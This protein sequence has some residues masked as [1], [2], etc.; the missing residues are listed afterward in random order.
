[1]RKL[2]RLCG[3]KSFVLVWAL[4]VYTKAS[5]SE[6][7]SVKPDQYFW[8]GYE[9]Y[10]ARSG[11]LRAR[12]DIWTKPKAGSPIDIAREYIRSAAQELGIPRDLNGFRVEERTV[13]P[14]KQITFI[15]EVRNVPVYCAEIR[16]NMS[17]DNSIINIVSS[18]EPGARVA[19]TNPKISGP[20]AEAFV[21]QLT[22]AITFT[23]PTKLF[24][25]AETE[26]EG[27]HLV[28]LVRTSGRPGL[29]PERIFIDANSEKVWRREPDVLRFVDGTGTVFHP[30]PRTTLSNN[31]LT[32]QNNSNYIDIQPAYKTGVALR[33]LNDPVNNVYRVQGK[34][35]TSVD[36]QSLGT[37]PNITPVT[38]ATPDFSFNRS[39]PGFEEVMAYY[40]IDTFARY[41]ASLPF[42]NYLINAPVEF[43]AHNAKEY[44]LTEY[45]VGSQ[46]I[47]LTEND[48]YFGVSNPNVDAGEDP[49]AI[50]HEL[51]HHF[52]LKTNQPFALDTSPEAIRIL[53]G[54][55]DYFG[56]SY[57]RTTPE[58]SSFNQELA[59]AWYL[60]TH[61]T[62]RVLSDLYHYPQQ[63]SGTYVPGGELW[64]ST[65]MD[66]EE[67]LGRDITT[68]LIFKALTFFGIGETMGQAALA[69]VDADKSLFAGQHV[70]ALVGVFARRGMME[71]MAGPVAGDQTWAGCCLVAGDVSFTS[72]SNLF[73]LPGATVV[74]ACSPIGSNLGE[75]PAGTEIIVQGRLQANG[76]AESPI[77][78]LS[79]SP[80]PASGDC[81]GFI[82]NKTGTAAASNVSYVTVKD[83]DWGICAKGPSSL[84]ASNVTVRDCTWGIIGRGTSSTTITGLVTQN[85]ATGVRAYETGTV[86]LSGST[87]SAGI[88][89]VKVEDSGFVSSSG[90][91]IY[92]SGTGFNVTG[93]H[94]TISG[95]KIASSSTGTGVRL[96]GSGTSVVLDNNYVVAPAATGIWGSIGTLDVRKGSVKNCDWGIWVDGSGSLNVGGTSVGYPDVTVSSCSI[97]GIGIDSPASCVLEDTKV[98]GTSTANWVGIHFL[99]GSNASLGFCEV[100]NATGSGS[101]GIFVESDASLTAPK[102]SQIAKTNLGAG[103]MFDADSLDTI[104]L[105]DGNG[106]TWDHPE[107]KDCY[108]GLSIM[109]FSRPV[110]KNSL[111]K[112]NQMYGVQIGPAAVPD[113]GRSNG[114]P[115]W[116]RNSIHG[117]GSSQGALLAGGPIRLGEFGTVK[118]EKN[119]WGSPIKPA[120]FSSWVDYD[121]TLT[122]D[123]IPVAGVSIEI[124]A[125][126]DL[127]PT[128]PPP[129]PM[130]FVDHVTIP[131]RV[132]KAGESVNIAIYDVAGRLVRQLVDGTFAFG[133]HITVWDGRGWEG[134]QFVPP[135]VYFAKTKIGT[136]I[137]TSK[138]V[139][140]R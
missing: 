21:Q 24:V 84:T 88:N 43:D 108:A 1:M 31:T 60:T 90:D 123:P 4:I 36:V 115:N 56:V 53:E 14:D 52:V 63:N 70:G 28:W 85:V 114:G 132:Q 105:D 46:R 128:P 64:A 57:R 16:V 121:P 120:Q 91:S 61:S 39:Q 86:A 47:I 136:S 82:L 55:S 131:F 111:V 76:T 97:E 130:P 29:D 58:G 103:I 139:V 59:S 117:V 81:N 17:A 93:G 8:K 49:S 12:H 110:I 79:D 18:Y 73:I 106:D 27:A 2:S 113:L 96:Q 112:D 50:I 9:K 124:G 30:D 35:A 7:Q 83:G 118:A 137:A 38:S 40:H 20:G 100:T 13:D 45:H 77:S 26:S 42:L 138:L 95:S 3:L 68:R 126:E 92:G 102:A 80:N 74:L 66:V 89:G 10:E 134:G 33:D 107:I 32:D 6:S 11:L 101:I 25:L 22:G 135:G 51:G 48:I 71:Y 119:W 125:L 87:V 72:T 109:G 5:A 62:D 65:V 133:D 37:D 78:I 127:Q 23:Q 69:F 19:S 67:A 129:Y 140:T 94:G 116:G 75:D 104:T 54:F 41:V 44:Q 122:S 98:T 99:P 34:Y 15:Q